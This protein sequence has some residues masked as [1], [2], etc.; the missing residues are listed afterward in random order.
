MASLADFNTLAEA[1]A[2]TETM[3]RL[4]PRN[5]M[6]AI[7]A[8]AGLSAALD[9]IKS[10]YGHPAQDAV[11]SFLDPGSIDY[12]FI[13]G[14]GTTTGDEQIASLD[15]MIS[16]GIS[17]TFGDGE[18]QRT[19]DV[20]AGLSIIRPELIA[21][22]NKTVHP[23][24]NTSQYEFD[25]AK[26]NAIAKKPLA[27]QQGYVFI[28]TTSDCGRHNPQILKKIGEHYVR[29]A[30]FSGVEQAG[31]YKAQVPSGELYVHDAYGVIA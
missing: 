13:V 30:S 28:T 31:E 16:A 27:Y 11:I 20:S 19:V 24:A 3:G 6:N 15:A 23:F 10:T 14:D 8:K 1:R 12:N 29:V 5:S 21:R 2:Y 25:L 17:V 4:I 22:C 18:L 7:L 26:G 9:Y